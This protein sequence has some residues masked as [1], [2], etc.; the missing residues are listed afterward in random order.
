[1]YWRAMRTGLA[2]A[3]FGAG[4]VVVAAVAFPVL[5]LLP[6]SQESRE[7]LA[8]RLI[9]HT[10]RL[11][12]WFMRALGLIRVEA[13]NTE[14]LGRRPCLVVANHPTLIDAVLLIASMPQADCVVKRAAWGSLF[15]RQVVIGAG[16]IPNEPADKLVELCVARLR[17]GRSVLLFPEGTRSPRGGLGQFH[18]GAA[19]VALATAC[20]LVP[21]VI[22]CDP[23]T[24]ARGEKWYE[25]PPRTARLSLRVGEPMRERWD[26]GDHTAMALATRRLTANLRRHYETRLDHVRHRH[27]GDRSEAPDHRDAHA[28]GCLGCRH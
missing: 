20:D 24:L 15:L 17:R 23:P 21:V 3:V 13:T 2:F 11:F 7:L 26:S 5:G 27:A 16:Y 10:F 28:R 25:V 1:M 19:R 22:T 8:Q 6:G 18:R 12:V 14:R 9:H 4:A